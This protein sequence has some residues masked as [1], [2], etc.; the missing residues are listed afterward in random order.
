MKLENVSHV[1]RDSVWCITRSELL[2]P[3][4]G[5]PLVQFSKLKVVICDHFHV[6]FM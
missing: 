1:G 2:E 4:Q 6:V 5:K 3:L